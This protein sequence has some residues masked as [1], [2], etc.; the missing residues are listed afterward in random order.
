MNPVVAGDFTDSIVLRSIGVLARSGSWVKRVR[1]RFSH[2]SS[3]MK[4]VKH[5]DDP[6]VRNYFECLV[7]ALT[8]HLLAVV[9]G[10]SVVVATI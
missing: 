1:E 3:T 7:V 4:S 2:H 5:G 8:S 6:T 10:N 9:G